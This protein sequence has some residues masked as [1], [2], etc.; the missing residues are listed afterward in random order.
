LR[1]G[2]LEGLADPATRVRA[3]SRAITRYVNDL[4][5]ERALDPLHLIRE[6]DTA[7]TAEI[8]KTMPVLQECVAEVLAES[9]V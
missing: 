9:R 3:A 1:V 8:L 6:M 7:E 4:S 2:A 5:D